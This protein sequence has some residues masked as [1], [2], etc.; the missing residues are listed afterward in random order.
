LQILD[1]TQEC[2]IGKQ[3]SLY[4]GAYLP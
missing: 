3:S 1:V 2:W 4:V